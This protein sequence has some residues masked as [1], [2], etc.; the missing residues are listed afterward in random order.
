MPKI[1]YFALPADVPERAIDFYRK[2]FGWQFELGWEYDTPHGRERYWHVTMG[3]GADGIRGGLT[4]REYPGQPI[5]VGIEVAAVDDCTSLVEKCGGKTIVGKVAVPG[6]A[7]F[8][9]CQDSEGNSFAIFQPD[10]GAR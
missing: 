9:M 2:V 3:D 7:W 4:R 5:S 10:A 8:A 1:N 6:V